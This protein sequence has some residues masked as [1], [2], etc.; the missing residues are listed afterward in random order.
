M[1]QFQ[2]ALLTPTATPNVIGQLYSPVRSTI[3]QIQYGKQ[4]VKEKI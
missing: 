3:E 1:I 4:G 2:K